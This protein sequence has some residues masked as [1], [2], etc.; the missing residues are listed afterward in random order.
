MFQSGKL[1]IAKLKILKHF[2]ELLKYFYH[3]KINEEQLASLVCTG[4]P[5][6]LVTLFT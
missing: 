3:S 2:L 5:Q 1:V 4:C 6:K